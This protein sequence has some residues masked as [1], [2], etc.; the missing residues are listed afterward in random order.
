MG[1]ILYIYCLLV[2]I[3]D[4]LKCALRFTVDHQLLYS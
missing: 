1:Q 3:Y 2:R 4:R